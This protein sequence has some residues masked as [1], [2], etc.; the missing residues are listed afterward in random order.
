MKKFAFVLAASA[1]IASQAFAQT[2]A[3]AGSGDAT[4]APAPAGADGTAKSSKI[5]KSDRKAARTARNAKMKA[6]S[7]DGSIPS[8]S[9]APKSY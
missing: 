1:L 5:S 2:A 3:P 6:A 7:K 4:A 8:P 9:V